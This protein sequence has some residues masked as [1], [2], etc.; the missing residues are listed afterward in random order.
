VFDDRDLPGGQLRYGVPEEKLPRAVLDAEIELIKRLGVAFRMKVRVGADVSIDELKKKYNA[1]VLAPGKIAPHAG[2][3]LGVKSDGKTVTADPHTFRTSDA[4]IFAGGEAVHPG[5]LAVRS[6]AHGRMIACSV[7]QYLGGK[8]VRGLVRRFDSRMGKVE[9]VEIFEFMKDVD[10][11]PGVEPA[12][13][14]SGGFSVEEAVK[15]TARC[16][17]C[18]CRKA[19]TCELRDLADRYGANQ[20]HFN[21]EGR[22]RFERITTH[23]SVIFEP[24]KCIKC[25]ICVRISERAHEKLGMTFV[26]RGFDA[27]VGV[28]FNESLGAGLESCAEECVKKC[29]TGALAFKSEQG[30]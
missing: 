6:C 13:G 24:G 12:S 2:D 7:E 27:F 9:D 22:K 28:P 20:K 21:V 26:G 4:A 8:D 10:T 19:S 29:P 16:M 15:E 17:H 18:D 3:V 25:G 23:S 5:H 14:A 30:S 11:S 1:I